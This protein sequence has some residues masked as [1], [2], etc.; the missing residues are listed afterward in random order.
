M[1]TNTSQLVA[2][3]LHA[4]HVHFQM[5]P[6]ER[7]INPV[8]MG[9]AGK[10]PYNIISFPVSRCW[11]RILLLIL[12]LNEFQR[13]GVNFEDKV[14]FPISNLTVM[15]YY[16]SF[17]AYIENTIMNRGARMVCFLTFL[18][19]NI[20]WFCRFDMGLFEYQVY[21]AADLTSSNDGY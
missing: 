18:Y 11:K 6:S 16:L 12:L 13:F 4:F 8:G 15:E 1:Q 7:H 5:P 17:T 19:C 2:K 3:E 14:L 9:G 20:L 21:G 10:I